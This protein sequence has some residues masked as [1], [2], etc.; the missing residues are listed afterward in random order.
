MKWNV[1]EWTTGNNFIHINDKEYD[2]VKVSVGG[3]SLAGPDRP[4][5][6]N[7]QF[8]KRIAKQWVV[9]CSSV[10]MSTARL[11]SKLAALCVDCKGYTSSQR[12]VEWRQ[13]GLA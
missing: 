10:F 4:W 8:E 3:E 6:L 2:P 13:T 12:L 1:R 11:D 9:G 5:L 7:V